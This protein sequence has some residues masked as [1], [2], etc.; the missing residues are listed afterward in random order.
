MGLLFL[1]SAR[2][3]QIKSGAEAGSQKGRCRDFHQ[4]AALFMHDLCLLVSAYR[5]L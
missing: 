2:L 1:K 5:S 4:A 3:C